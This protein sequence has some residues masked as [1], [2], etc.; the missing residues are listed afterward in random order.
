MAGNAALL[1]HAPNTPRCGT[2]IEGLMAE[3]G[4]PP[5]LVRSLFLSNEQA[6]SVMADSRVRGVTSTGSTRA[7]REVAATAGSRLKT[8]VMELGGS[9]PFVVFD[10]AELERAVEVGAFA[11]CQNS[12]QSCIAAKRFI[13]ERSRFDEF[14]DRFVERMSAQKVGDP[15]QPGVKIGPLARR[16]L[17]DSLATQVETTLA[18]GGRALCGGSVPQGQ[19]FFYPPTVLVDAAPGTPA[20]DDELFG[21]RCELVDGGQ[22]PGAATRRDDRGRERLRQRFGQVRSTLAR[23][24]RQGLRLRTRAGPRGYA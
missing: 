13:V 12:G 7:G 17:R 8:M 16:D 22:G 14:R 15:T 10:D 6:A 11:R 24:R 18:A 9:D 20:D 19:G 4:F 21:A 5:G 23:R 1:K 2:T 3:A